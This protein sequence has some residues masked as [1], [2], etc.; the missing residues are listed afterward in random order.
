MVRALHLIGMVQQMSHS[1]LQ[2]RIKL[3]LVQVKAV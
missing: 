1:W 2:S 3:L